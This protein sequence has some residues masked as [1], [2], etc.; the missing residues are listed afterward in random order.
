V[1][2]RE[3]VA[4]KQRANDEI[5]AYARRQGFDGTDAVPFVCECRRR[6]VEVLVGSLSDYDAARAAATGL[7]APDH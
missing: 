6:C 5:A 7:T 4:R 2:T 3:I 1:D